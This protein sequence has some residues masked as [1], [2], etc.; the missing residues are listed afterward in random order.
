MSNLLRESSIHSLPKL[1][2]GKVRDIYAV[3]DD[4]LLI[5]VTDRVSAFD[6]T[7]PTLVPDK[8]K[9]LTSISNAWFEKLASIVP[10]H[11]TGILPETVVSPDEVDQV[12]DRAVVVKKLKPIPF[13]A[14]VRGYLAGSGWKSYQ[15]SRIINGQLIA[16]G[17]KLASKLPMPIFTPTTKA[18][19]GEHDEPVI[20]SR[21]ER[22]IGS[23][24][25]NQI[26][27]ISL[28]LYVTARDIAINSGLILADT[29]FEFGID[30]DGTLT[31][32]DEILTPDSSRIWDAAQY[33][34]GVSPP[35]LDK[36]FLR[37]YLESI[38]WDKTPPAPTLPDDIVNGLR[39]RYIRAYEAIV[40]HPFEA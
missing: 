29:K 32:M 11:L 25:A 19:N 31:L 39:D 10:N 35:S 17:L 1:Y 26:R 18:P 5:V 12:K 16:P 33:Q 3:G 23:S 4:K 22:Q 7:S 13:E 28:D 30:S 8:G 20:F 34:E 36:Q 21:L 40:G 27:D 24:M 15:S 14:V 6:A 37:D 2:S 9:L 38:E